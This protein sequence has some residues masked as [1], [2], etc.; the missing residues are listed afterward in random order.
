MFKCM[1]ANE[2]PVDFDTAVMTINATIRKAIVIIIQ[3]VLAFIMC[4]QILKKSVLYANFLC[5]DFVCK[6]NFD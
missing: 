6:Y 3:N 4:R 1:I 5:I 2:L